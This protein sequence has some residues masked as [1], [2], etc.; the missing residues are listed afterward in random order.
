MISV[1]RHNIDIFIDIYGLIFRDIYY[2][3]ND[4]LVNLVFHLYRGETYEGKK[5]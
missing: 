1:L 2:I 3:V 5:C 4:Q